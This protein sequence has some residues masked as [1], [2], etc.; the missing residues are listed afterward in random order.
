MAKPVCQT[1]KATKCAEL[2]S[3]EAKLERFTTDAIAADQVYADKPVPPPGYR[4]ATDDDLIGLGLSR[5]YIESPYD[6]VA[7]RKSDFKATV[8]VNET[9]GEKLVAFRGSGARLQDWETNL[10]QARGK[11]SFYY[12][13]AQSI[14]K[15]IADA[16]G[17]GNTRFTGHSLGGGLASAAARATGLP[18]STFNAAGLHENTVNDPNMSTAIDAV[19]VRGEALTTGQMIPGVAKA[20]AT[21]SWPLDPPP[22]IGAMILTR[23]ASALAGIKGWAAAKAARAADLH[24]MVHVHESISHRKMQVTTEKEKNNC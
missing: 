16:P 23:A 19:Y 22:S 3:E 11:E 24:R 13:R 18:A 14:A 9:T 7:K 20:A 17:G 5:S 15:T 1:C 10:D 4:N 12:T 6:E 8:F 21:K 2:R